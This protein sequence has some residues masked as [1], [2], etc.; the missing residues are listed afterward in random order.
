[1]ARARVHVPAWDSRRAYWGDMR[2]VSV[3]ASE[4]RMLISLNVGTICS[5]TGL[6]RLGLIMRER[7]RGSE[8]DYSFAL[9]STPPLAKCLSPL[10][11]KGGRVV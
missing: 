8:P 10:T 4:G 2:T 1:M 3:G 7:R 9:R 11:G 5:R 6:P